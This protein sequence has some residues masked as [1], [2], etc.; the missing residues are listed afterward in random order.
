M[1][2]FREHEGSFLHK[3][4]LLSHQTSLK[5]LVASLLSASLRKEQA[6][7]RTM[8]ICL[9]NLH[10]AIWCQNNVI[11]GQF[12]KTV[13]SIFLI[14]VKEISN[15]T[16]NQVMSIVPHVLYLLWEP[17]PELYKQFRAVFIK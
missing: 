15:M 3:Q 13:K 7:Q 10:F 6:E 14:T 11:Y 8:L 5:G 2:K 1:Q 4:A 16:K 17:Y 12:G 9:M